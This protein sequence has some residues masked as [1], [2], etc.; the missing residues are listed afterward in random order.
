VYLLVFHAYFTGILIFKG[1]TARRLYK[2][3]G[4]KGLTYPKQLAAGP[5]SYSEPDETSQYFNTCNQSDCL[6]FWQLIIL[7]IC[8]KA[9]ASFSG[10]QIIGFLKT[11]INRPRSVDTAHNQDL[12]EGVPLCFV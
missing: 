5:Y 2:S 7:Y 6:K 1:F 8:N 3:F 12:D 9:Q 10:S 4:F 11:S